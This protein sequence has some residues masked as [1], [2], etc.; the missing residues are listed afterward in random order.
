ML[1]VGGVSYLAVCT[2]KWHVDL[3]LAATSGEAVGEMW[4]LNAT[5]SA[6]LLLVNSLEEGP[7]SGAAR[8][9]GVNSDLDG[10][11]PKAASQL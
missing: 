2:A 8:G 3:D 5:A 7:V 10:H 9:G 11:L 6:G 4:S 1:G